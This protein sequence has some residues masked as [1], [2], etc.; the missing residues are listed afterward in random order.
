MSVFEALADL[1]AATVMGKTH[2]EKA[3]MGMFRTHKV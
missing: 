2:R 3:G 1:R